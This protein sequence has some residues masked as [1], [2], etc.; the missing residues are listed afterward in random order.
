[1]LQKLYL[2]YLDRVFSVMTPC[3]LGAVYHPIREGHSIYLPHFK[4]TSNFVIKF[5]D[6]T[7][8]KFRFSLT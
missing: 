5:F 8:S 2:N 4:V 6:Y 7:A 1:M 3:S